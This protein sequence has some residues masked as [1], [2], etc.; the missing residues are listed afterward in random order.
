MGVIADKIRRAI[1]GGEVRDS[2]A[3]GIEVVE[4]LREDYDNQV[5][6]A[7][8]SNAEI[9]DARGGQT[10]L[11]DRLDNFDEQLEHIENNKADK[12]ELNKKASI[13]E[14]NSVKLNKASLIDLEVERKRIDSLI[15]QGNGVDNAETSDI[16]VSASG[17]KY[18]SAGNSVRETQKGN[19]ILDN[20]ITPRHLSTMKTL[21]LFNG[22]Y[23]QG[24][25]IGG[26][27]V[28]NMTLSS[29]S[30][31]FLIAI[32]VEPSTTYSI[33]YGNDVGVED[34][35][36]WFKIASSTKTKS[37]V[38]SLS[39]TGSYS[40]DGS[41]AFSNTSS[42]YQAG[43][44]I[45]TSAT[46]K[47]L[48]ILVSKYTKPNYFEVIKGSRSSK[49]YSNYDNSY[50]FYNKFMP[51]SLVKKDGNEIIIYLKSKVNENYIYIIFKRQTDNSRKLDTWRIYEIGI[52]DYKFDK[53]SILQTDTDQEGA[54]EENG[55]DDFI[56]GFH[57]DEYYNKIQIVIDGV[58][59]N[60]SD[61]IML[62]DFNNIKIYVSSIL[63]RCNT[64]TKVFDRV[65]VLEFS[66]DGYYT[67]E[68]NLTC[69]NSFLIKRLATALFSV[70]KQYNSVSNIT[71]YTENRNYYPVAIPPVS[72]TSTALIWGNDI[73]SIE[74]YG[75]GLYT[76]TSLLSTKLDSFN[77][78]LQDFGSRIKVY[79]DP[80]KNLQM[81]VGD[82]ISTK[83]RVDI[84][85]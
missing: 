7:G 70:D 24:K 73:T 38:L 61:Y 1:F 85:C 12:I 43:Q 53:L 75:N 81:N 6:N 13:E 77:A 59:Y 10:K 22:Q 33:F 20:A 21:N 25:Y 79:L 66:A 46:D 8:N 72:A 30:N 2:I 23:I 41:I 74:M 56:G 34:S 32:D 48:F 52:C 17:L 18:T 19:A 47:S 9:V 58:V 16:R 29:N 55:A 57:G 44:K 39:D 11:K 80:A 68:N 5:I 26:S 63:N 42:S 3:D 65:K 67:V 37:E 49:L 31:Y 40:F 14:L 4:Q 84:K 78:T 50:K 54:I 64:T 36:Y 28:G 62:K 69:V 15:S 83:F 60:E 45:T 76:K 35:H 51:K 27:T 71:Y 82:K